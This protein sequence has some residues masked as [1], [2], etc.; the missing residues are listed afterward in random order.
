MAELD[1]EKEQSNNRLLDQAHAIIAKKD[2]TNE[3][4][5]KSTMRLYLKEKNRLNLIES[6]KKGY[7]EMGK[8]NLE[9]AELYMQCDFIDLI[10]Y[11]KYV[12]EL[13]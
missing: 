3:E 13:L 9:L 11:E 4:F 6:I 12:G 10:S 7:E 5:I 2:M 8:I 1:R